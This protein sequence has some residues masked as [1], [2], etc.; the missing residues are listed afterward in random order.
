MKVLHYLNQFFAGIGGEEKAGKKGA[1]MTCPGGE[2][3]ATR[4]NRKDRGMEY[5]TLACGDN[6][7]HEKE[8]KALT[9]IRETLKKFRP[10]LF[11][12]GPAFNAGRSGLACAKVCSWVRD[13]WRIPAVTG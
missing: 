7:F 13:N 5:A 8:K 1:F 3:G 11:L 6:Y 2:G 10:D 4:N 9:M 12:A